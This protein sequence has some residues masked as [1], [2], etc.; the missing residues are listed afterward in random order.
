MPKRRNLKKGR[1]RWG[2][3]WS[4]DFTEE[5]VSTILDYVSQG[6]PYSVAAAR[7]GVSPKA[8][9]SWRNRAKKHWEDVDFDSG[10]EMNEWALFYDALLLAVE[11]GKGTYIDQVR[12]GQLGKDG[13]DWKASARAASWVHP[14]E[15]GEKVLAKSR[16][17]A[18]VRLLDAKAESLGRI[19]D[20]MDELIGILNSA[21]TPGRVEL[22]S[23]T[24][25]D[26]EVSDG[27]TKRKTRGGEEGIQETEA[28][29]GNKVPSAGGRAESGNKNIIAGNIA[30]SG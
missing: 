22:P 6:Y 14:D 23:P 3:P 13:P 12:S 2:E 27:E 29:H 5:N 20:G 28:W 7:A 18:E 9:S 11:L 19:G 24:V 1:K 10:D 26:A 25:L 15:F 17:A 4:A 30:R 21:R 16:A 8:A